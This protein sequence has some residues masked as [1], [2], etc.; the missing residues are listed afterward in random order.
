MQKQFFITILLI[1]H[2]L[3]IGNCQKLKTF[4]VTSKTAFK[5][6]I[7]DT[8]WT[9]FRDTF[10]ILEDTAKISFFEGLKNG[11]SLGILFNARVHEESTYDSILIVKHKDI[12]MARLFNFNKNIDINGMATTEYLNRFNQQISLVK[13]QILTIKD[14]ALMETI[15]K[16]LTL[17]QDD[18]HPIE[19]DY[20]ISINGKLINKIKNDD[21]NWNSF[22]YLKDKIF[23]IN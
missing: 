20:F 8:F 12:L 13:V 23:G 3:V 19:R 21:C 16:R 7:R 9:E 14:I 4:S 15:F 11:D 1:A 17:P 5:D 6:T 18:C 22:D 2:C 10:Y